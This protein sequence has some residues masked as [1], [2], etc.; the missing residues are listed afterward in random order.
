MAR[1]AP[2]QVNTVRGVSLWVLRAFGAF[3]VGYGAFLVLGRL[4]Y[5]FVIGGNGAL[6]AHMSVG[7]DHGL[8][9]GIPMLFLGVGLM[10]AGRKIARWVIA[11]PEQGCPRC[12]YLGTTSGGTCPECGLTGLEPMHPKHPE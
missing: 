9:R 12:R 2:S 7:S 6:R 3:L 1:I 4:V 10:L 5:A 8:V 11:M